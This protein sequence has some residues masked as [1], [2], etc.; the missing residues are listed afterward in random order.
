MIDPQTIFFGVY[1]ESKNS[2]NL[3]DDD[4]SDFFSRFNKHI[5]DNGNPK[6]AKEEEKK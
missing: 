2:E 1:E 3:D 4:E 5:K 6:E